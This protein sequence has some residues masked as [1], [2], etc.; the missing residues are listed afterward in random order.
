MRYLSVCINLE[1]ATSA[2]WKPAA[3]AGIE[4]F[5]SAVLARNYWSWSWPAEPLAPARAFSGER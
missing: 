1:A 4:R 5:P 3:F 2:C